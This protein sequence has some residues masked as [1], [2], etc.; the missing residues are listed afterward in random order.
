[1][2]VLHVIPSVSAIHGGPS[3]ALVTMTRALAAQGVDV[4][5]ATTDDDGKAHLRVPHEQAVWRDGVRYWF[6]PRQTQFYKFSLPLTRWLAAHAADYDILHLHALFSYASLPAA[7]YAARA[8]VPYIVRP[9]GTLNQYGMTRHHPGLKQ[10]S[11]SLVEQNILAHAARLHFTS[12]QEQAEASALHLR[13]PSVV[14]PLGIPVDSVA[15]AHNSHWLVTHASSLQGQT[16]FLFLGRLDPKKGVELLLDAFARIPDLPAAL[17]IAGDGAAAYVTSLQS[18]ARALGLDHRVV[19]AG[20]VQGAD[21]TALYAAADC[22]VLPSYSENFGIAVVEAMA[23]GLPVIVSTEVGIQREIQEANA[24][25]IVPPDAAA[26]A[27]A[28]CEIVRSPEQTKMRGKNARQ[29]ARASFSV[30][31]MTERLLQLYADVIAGARP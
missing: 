20:F 17:V 19:W 30:E 22:F 6:F 1:M 13:T 29:L 4:D 15:P 3:A 12:E 5:V 25:I 18:R 9:L 28:M 23:S 10:L 14:I 26:L 21:K 31:R 8:H 2:R 24:G 7:Y 11:F 16:L 27:Q